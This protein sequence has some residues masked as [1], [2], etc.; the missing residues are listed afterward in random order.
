MRTSGIAG[1]KTGRGRQASGVGGGVLNRGRGGSTGFCC[2]S[3]WQ[4]GSTWHG[5]GHNIRANE[6][7]QVTLSGVLETATGTLTGQM[8]WCCGLGGVG[9]FSG[10]IRGSSL[11]LTQNTGSQFGLIKY[12]GTISTSLGG[13]SGTY[14]YDNGAYKGTWQVSRLGTAAA[15]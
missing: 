12:T 5:T 10:A 2:G 9:P 11:R 1:R 14:E 4:V 15:V 13:I 8:A 3:L 6:S 7:G